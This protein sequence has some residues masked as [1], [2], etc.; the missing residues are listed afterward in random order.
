[1]S[2][3]A[4]LI[5]S[6]ATIDQTFVDRCYQDNV[7]RMD[8]VEEVEVNAQLKAATISFSCIEMINVEQ[9]HIVNVE[10]E[11]IQAEQLCELARLFPKLETLQC[12]ISEDSEQKPWSELFAPFSHL[13][14]LDCEWSEYRNLDFVLNTNSGRKDEGKSL[15]TEME[16][17][18]DGSITALTSVDEEIRPWKH[19]GDLQILT[20]LLITLEGRVGRD[21]LLAWIGI[22]LVALA[23]LEEFRFSRQNGI[24]EVEI[25]EALP[26]RSSFSDKIKEE[27][28]KV[29]LKIYHN[30][31][32]FNRAF[33]DEILANEKKEI[34][35]FDLS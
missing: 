23:K 6:G 1:M 24:R 29:S 16:I 21:V 22:A 4:I 19:Y 5:G 33:K 14:S 26:I 11:E 8:F 30:E 10:I 25:L 3:N 31:C 27:G 17:V 7:E 15:I 32:I 12:K 18:I 2:F 35:L 20:K 13:R 34:S 28:E 9:P